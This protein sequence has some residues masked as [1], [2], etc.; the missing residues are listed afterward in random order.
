MGLLTLVRAKIAQH[1]V[2]ASGDTVVVAVSG[3]PDSLALLH[4]LRALRD[5]LQITLHVAHLNHQLRGSESDADAEFVASVARDWNL[6]ATVAARDVAALA[7]ENRLSIEEAAR[8]ARYAFLGQ[9]AQQVGAQ[10]IA[11]AHNADDQV[12]TVLMHFLR[13]AGLAGLRGMGYTS[14]V[15]SLKSQ[16]SSPKSQVAISTVQ[17]VRPLLD[18]TRAEIEEYCQEN[19]LTPRV[20]RSNLDTTFFRNRLRHEALPYLET[21]N[22]NLREVLRHT[23]CV[24][25]DDYDFLQAQVRE[26]YAHV[27]REDDG[28]ITFGRDAWRNLHPALQRGTLRL[29]VQ[30]LRADLRD[31]DWAHVEEARRV[32]MEKGAGAK[33]TLPHGLMLVVGYDDFTIADATREPPLPDWPFLTRERIALPIPSVVELPGSEWVVSVERAAGPVEAHD[34]WTALL[35]ADKIEGELALRH[36]RAGD[37]FEPVGMAGHS[38]SLHEFM[39]DEKIPHAVR[40][41][42]PILVVNDR[43]LWVCGWRVGERARATMETQH[44]LRITFRKNEK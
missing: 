17:L 2:F 37:R 31:V 43:I 41:R 39:I 21:L 8:H 40:D 1:D 4:A 13:G 44:V 38:K 30:A 19:G 25:A 15:P 42:L 7:R 3:G 9:V 34:R 6:P 36:R 5:E 33:A 35:D 27:T 10:N 24:L 28:A 11:V 22:P 16:V 18:V 32:A 26:A 14:Q 23:A 29:A 20:D 12:E